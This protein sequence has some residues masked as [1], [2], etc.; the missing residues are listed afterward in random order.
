MPE[1]M[2]ILY[3]NADPPPELHKLN[4]YRDDNR[5]C[6][7]FYTDPQFFFNLWRNEVMKENENG[8]KAEKRRK[9]V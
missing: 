6:M 2:R 5:D 4:Q 8:R 7:K 1:S 3:E 9:K